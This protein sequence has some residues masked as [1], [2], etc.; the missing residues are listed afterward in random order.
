MTRHAIFDL[1]GTLVDSLPGIA[2]SIDRALAACC[3][4][5]RQ[6]ELRPL[7]G[8][9]IR[10]ILARVSGLSNGHAL[11]TLER[12]FRADYDSDGWRRTILYGGVAELLEELAA[13]HTGLWV[14]TNKPAVA[15][16]KILHHLALDRFFAEVVC[17]DSRRLPYS[18]KQEALI[19]LTVRRALSLPY[20]IL[21]GD[22]EEDR[23]A[24]AAA[25]VDCVIVAHGYGSGQAYAVPKWGAVRA[26][27]TAGREAA[28][29]GSY[30]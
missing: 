11:D 26:W 24:A 15:T 30:D 22:T 5:P 13:D 12:A 4:P 17:R 29:V 19:D 20:C 18:S 14:V 28:E 1:D 7:I 8:P 3:L 27:A 21:I 2:W 23:R 16:A 6:A 9:P 25:G 10:S